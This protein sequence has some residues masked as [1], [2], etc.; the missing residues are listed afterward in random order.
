MQHR[1]PYS[2]TKDGFYETAGS[3]VEILL[4]AYRGIEVRDKMAPERTRSAS[5]RSVS[6]QESAR[7]SPN[8]TQHM[9]ETLC[10]ALTNSLGAT[11]VRLSESWEAKMQGDAG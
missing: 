6:S 11:F 8:D 9:L 2:A 3:T 7:A 1:A 4:S 5:R 10:S